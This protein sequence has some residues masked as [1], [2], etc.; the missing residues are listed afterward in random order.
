M[1]LT[2]KL[3]QQILRFGTVGTTA[4][5]VQVGLVTLFVEL[6]VLPPL[7]ANIIAFFL[8]FQV[9][10]WGHR[11]WTFNAAD[12]EHRV[13]LPR[14]FL[15]ASS[16]FVANETLFYIFLKDFHLQYILALLLVLTILPVITFSLSKFWVF[17]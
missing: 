11:Q 8:A 10:Y 9:S 1:V 7:A 2:N 5:G 15:I 17:R 3:F 16:G 12:R 14:L 6:N 4:A 13:T